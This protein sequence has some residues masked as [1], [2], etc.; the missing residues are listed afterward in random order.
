[1]PLL[2]SLLNDK[3]YFVENAA[4][5]GI[6]KSIKNLPDGNQIKGKMIKILKEKVESIT[7]QDQLAQGAINGLTELVNDENIEIVEKIVNLLINKSN[8]KD[9]VLNTPNRYFVRAAATLALGKFL[10][11][12]NQKIINDNSL[13]VRSKTLNNLVLS[14]L[15]QLL[16][17]E[18]RRIKRNACTALADPD[19]KIIEPSERI[20]KS[21]D[22][23][24]KLAEEDL[25]GFVRRTAEVSLNVIR[26]WL[27]EWTDKEPRLDIQVR[28]DI[29][30][31]IKG[32]KV[33]KKTKKKDTENKDEKT[34]RVSRKDFIEY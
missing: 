17:D 7:F 13:K 22:K 3:S 23:L 29:D 30:D 33:N 1:V 21:I 31:K 11:I 8:K 28:K 15:I 9:S 10:I 12:R 6:G 34:L 25:D 20:I 4:A 18:S 14:H 16:K 26:G 5:T 24:K 27:K 32:I 2:V 19:S